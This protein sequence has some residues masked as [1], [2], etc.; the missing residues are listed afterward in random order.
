MNT[1]ETIGC[2]SNYFDT[3][4]SERIFDILKIKHHK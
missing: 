3:R 1:H 4:I 2:T